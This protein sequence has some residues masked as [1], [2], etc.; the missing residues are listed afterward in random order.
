MLAWRSAADEWP[1]CEDEGVFTRLQV[2]GF[3]VLAK[4]TREWVA[5][6]NGL[7]PTSRFRVNFS[8][9]SSAARSERFFFKTFFTEACSLTNGTSGTSPPSGSLSESL[10]VL[11][12]KDPIESICF[13]D[14]VKKV[15]TSMLPVHWSSHDIDST[16]V[17]SCER[18]WSVEPLPRWSSLLQYT[19]N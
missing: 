12:E 19:S 6:E 8:I 18:K 17:N 4:R 10:E 7:K 15:R 11:I 16:L 2:S 3:A 5:R 1:K 13:I 14:R 9:R